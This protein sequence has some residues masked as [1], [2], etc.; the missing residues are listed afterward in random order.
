MPLEKLFAQL[1]SNQAQAPEKTLPPNE[2]WNPP[3]CGAIDIEIKANG[4]WYHSGAIINRL[5]LVKLFAS[6]LVKKSHHDTDEYFLITPVESVKINV[7]DAPF[8]IT[9]WRWLDE[10]ESIMEVETNLVDNFT[11]D[12]NHRFTIA[13][14][15]CIY[16]VV[17]QNLLAKV[18]RNVYYQWIDLANEAHKRDDKEESP[19]NSANCCLELFFYSNQHKFIVGYC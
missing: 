16:V 17:R 8:L 13:E 9:Q 19:L 1:S 7:V 11:L 15:G 10:N 6:V 14:N 18:H 12:E 3:Y 5:A 4:D 2:Q